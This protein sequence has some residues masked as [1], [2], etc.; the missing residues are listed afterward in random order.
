[1]LE[2]SSRGGNPSVSAPA[3][4]RGTIQADEWP[5][6]FADAVFLAWPQEAGERLCYESVTSLHAP[7][8]LCLALGG[9]GSPLVL[10][11]PPRPD[12]A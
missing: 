2:L 7:H 11:S 5:A 3:C 9:E 12:P 10:H 4:S 6:R 1:M 8:H